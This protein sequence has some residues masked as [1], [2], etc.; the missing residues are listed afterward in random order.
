MASLATLVTS[1]VFGMP[2]G[3]AQAG[4]Q[5]SIRPMS[6]PGSVDVATISNIGPNLNFS[7]FRVLDVENWSMA[8][9]G[10]I[11][12]WDYLTSGN[13]KN[14][15][16]TTRNLGGS[17][18]QII[19]VNS[20]LCLDKSMDNGDHDGALVYQYTCDP[21]NRSNQLWAIEPGGANG[22]WLIQSAE[23]GRCLDIRDK[24]PNIDAS[25]QVWSCSGAWNQTWFAAPDVD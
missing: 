6:G 21:N 7:P 13:V 15:R 10:R 19:N 8:N 2:G 25:L 18:Y 12:M 3:V 5:S 22:G 4:P 17:W 9:R 23:D 14:Q 1:L 11:H 16:W 24:N 20:H